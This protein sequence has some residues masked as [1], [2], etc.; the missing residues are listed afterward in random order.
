M[1]RI[2]QPRRFHVPSWKDMLIVAVVLA[3]FGYVLYWAAS[4][5]TSA[6]AVPAVQQTLDTTQG[7][8]AVQP[9]QQAPGAVAPT[10]EEWP[11]VEDGP[12]RYTL[13][14][15]PVPYVDDPVYNGRMSDRLW[16]SPGSTFA[17]PID[18]TRRE[19]AKRI[20]PSITER[21][22]V[23]LSITRDRDNPMIL[24]GA[25]DIERDVQTGVEL[26]ARKEYAKANEVARLQRVEIRLG[27]SA[28]N[29]KTWRVIPLSFVPD[30]NGINIDHVIATGVSPV[31]VTVRPFS[32]PGYWQREVLP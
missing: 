17:D 12:W 27:I 9:V 11:N 16:G 22:S 8:P 10:K 18:N 6:P 2:A 19:I 29:G 3:G 25:V 30:P 28:D 4:R 1:A 21:D 7:K 32:S 31:L 5:D 23:G 14:I 24:L 13:A 15:D 20:V 26:I